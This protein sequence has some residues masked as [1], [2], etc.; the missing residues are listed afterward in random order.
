[1]T[2]TTSCIPTC[3]QFTFWGVG[4]C[5]ILWGDSCNR[6]AA[7]IMD[8]H[9]MCVQDP[10]LGCILLVWII[11]RGEI[12]SVSAVPFH[13][14]SAGRGLWRRLRCWRRGGFGSRRWRRSCFCCGFGR[15]C[16]RRFRRGRRFQCGFRRLN[17][18][19]VFLRHGRAWKGSPGRV[20][21]S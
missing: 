18:F 6:S 4:G 13:L 9:R 15:R 1:M 20:V 3:Q 10:C 16:C 21:C 5:V 14:R 19:R 17:W 2:L 8:F 12:V 7:G 11:P